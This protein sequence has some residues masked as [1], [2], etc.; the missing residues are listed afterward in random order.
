MNQA[1]ATVPVEEIETLEE[2]ETALLPLY[3]VVLWDDDEHSFEYVISMLN[4]LFGYPKTKGFQLAKRVDRD[5]R[6]VV[7]TSNF[8]VAE[9]KRDQILAYG[10]DERIKKCTGS[11]W[12]TIEKVS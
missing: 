11:M 6:T 2:N 1:S 9:L 5:G 12:A 8:E 7:F 4:D 10:K 3:H